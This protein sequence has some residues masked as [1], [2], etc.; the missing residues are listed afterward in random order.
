MKRICALGL[1]LV[2]AVLSGLA[3]AT[4]IGAKLEGEVLGLKEDGT[5]LMKDSVYGEVLVKTGTGTVWEGLEAPMEGWYVFVDYDGLMTRSLPP[6]VTADKVVCY[7]LE[8]RVLEYDG[9]AGR[10]LL[11]TGDMGRLLVHLREAMPFPAQPEIA[12]VFHQGIIALSEPGQVSAL[13]AE[14]LLGIS[15]TVTEKEED[16]LL[17]ES[18]EGTVRVNLGGRS[19]LRTGAEVGEK[20]RVY[21]NGIQTFSLPPQVFGDIIEAVGEEQQSP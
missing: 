4:P 15:G 20:V 11:E 9:D 8:G 19:L 7:R 14:L 1:F 16:W 10:M 6:Q 3:A 12:V 21:Y 13:K 5:F 17:L 18:V 2:F